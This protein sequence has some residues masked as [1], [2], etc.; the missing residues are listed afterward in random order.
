MNHLD[1]VIAT[2]VIW[3]AFAAILIAAPNVSH[4]GF[5]VMV[6]AIAA[7]VPTAIMWESTRPEEDDESAEE[8]STK[9]KRQHS[10]I[11]RL[12]E[13][14][15]EDELEELRQRLMANEDGELVELDTLLRDEHR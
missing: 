4:D 12:V 15:D 6:L 2:S 10:P 14:L 1:R 8:K 11:A 3:T 13:V 9:S 5:I 7:G